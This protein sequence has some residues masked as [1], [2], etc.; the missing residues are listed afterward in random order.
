MNLTSPIL[1]KVMKKLLTTYGTL[2]PFY[3]FLVPLAPAKNL[4]L[5]VVFKSLQ[6][7][8]G[9]GL[10]SGGVYAPLQHSV[11]V[12]LISSRTSAVR[13]CNDNYNLS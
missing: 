4:F 9:S 8:V 12:I 6:R 2:R 3:F 10:D 11:F 1:E 13:C 7:I 5:I